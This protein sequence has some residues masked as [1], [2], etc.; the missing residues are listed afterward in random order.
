MVMQ[1][2]PSPSPHLRVSALH[3]GGVQHHSS[4]RENAALPPL[5]AALRGNSTSG[6]RLSHSGRSLSRRLY[7]TKGHRCRRCALVAFA[8]ALAFV[9]LYLFLP[10]SNLSQSIEQTFLTSTPAPSALQEDE[11]AVPAPLIPPRGAFCGLCTE[12]L[13]I[14]RPAAGATS[15]A[16]APAAAEHVVCTETME[17]AWLLESRAE[18]LTTE[19]D[20]VARLYNLGLLHPPRATIL[21]T[22]GMC[23]TVRVA[24]QV[25]SGEPEASNLRECSS[26]FVAALQVSETEPQKVEVHIQRFPSWPFPLIALQVAAGA[27]GVDRGSSEGKQDSIP[28]YFATAAVKDTDADCDAPPPVKLYATEDLREVVM[29]FTE[30]AASATESHA[31][32]SERPLRCPTYFLTVRLGRFGRH[33]NQL[34]EVLNGISLARRTN[35]TFILPPFVPA[36]YMPY[37]KVSPELLYGW[38]TLR[39]D[40]RYCILSYAEAR[41]VLQHLREREGS[42]SIERVNFAASVDTAVLLNTTEEHDR[43]VWGSIPRVQRED[44]TFVYNADDWFSAGFRKRADA[45]TLT[46]SSEVS[47]TSPLELH[48]TSPPDAEECSGFV[49]PAPK[50]DSTRW[51]RMR[52]CITAFLR[53][54]GDG[55][56]ERESLI[57]S[58]RQPRIVVLSSVTAFHLRPTLMEM[59]RLLGLLRPSSAL[60]KEFERY[61]R[62]YA[63]QLQLPLGTDPAQASSSVLQPF[64]FRGV[65]GI[66]VRRREGTCR[67]EA[68]YPSGTIIAMSKARYQFDGTGEEDVAASGRPLTTVARLANDCEWNVQ[69]LL[70]IYEAYASWVRSLYVRK[71]RQSPCFAHLAPPHAQVP[72][73]YIAFDEQVGPIGAQ[74]QAVL[75]DRYNPQQEER[76]ANGYPPIFSAFY[77]RRSRNDLRQV[78]EEIFSSRMQSATSMQHSGSQA[79]TS[80]TSTPLTRSSLVEI[81]YPIAEQEALALAFDFFMLSNTAVFRG[82]IISSVSINVCLRR[83]GRGLPCHGALAGYYEMLYKGYV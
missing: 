45:A 22:N 10:A 73:S 39:R 83:W 40:G 80:N 59:T 24:V 43:Y 21:K 36:L 46:A 19:R 9:L 31:P 17:D 42:V 11:L 48:E 57:A 77:D 51:E 55:D 26:G 3:Q 38:N 33:H 72:R 20:C 28:A 25:P 69:S 52:R 30:G 76:A 78:Y 14:F 23:A 29:G 64:R 68:E 18:P 8:F 62:L 16:A 47:V 50:D 13:V 65:I 82:N 63:A 37:M 5:L 32:P 60:T 81:L 67:K 56:G 12:G 34:Q 7:Q 41:P 1:D 53:A 70:Q 61:Y 49:E 35:R 27:K 2:N 79:A 58:D 44:G 74:L 15:T 75:Q 71:Q 6:K 66:H 4:T 54:Y